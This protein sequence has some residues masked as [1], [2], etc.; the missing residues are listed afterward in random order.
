M[1]LNIGYPLAFSEQTSHSSAFLLPL[2]NIMTLPAGQLSIP[3]REGTT[4]VHLR[5]VESASQLHPG[6]HSE[7]HHPPWLG[8]PEHEV[9]EPTTRGP[10]FLSSLSEQNWDDGGAD[11]EPDAFGGT[12]LVCLHL[13]LAGNH[14]SSS[15]FFTPD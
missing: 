6:G 1:S 4:E 15:C 11:R 9:S 13:V 2:E 12:W 14:K 3:G 8:H 7:R 10:C 5:T